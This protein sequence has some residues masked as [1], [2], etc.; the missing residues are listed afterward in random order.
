MVDVIIVVIIVVII[1]VNI[2]VIILVNVVV[3]I[4]IIS[5][6]NMVIDVKIIIARRG[7]KPST[8]ANPCCSKALCRPTGDDH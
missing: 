2:V 6:V 7:G 4:V 3:I 5:I 1:L 8:P